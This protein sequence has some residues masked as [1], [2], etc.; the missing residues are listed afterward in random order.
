MSSPALPLELAAVPL[1]AAA[2]A[3]YGRVIEPT[4]TSRSVNLGTAL[5]YDWLARLENR[6]QH[7]RLNVAFFRCAAQPLPL[8]IAL[9]ERHPGSTQLFVPMA[10]SPYLVVV[11]GEAGL[12]AFIARGQGIAYAPGV[13]HA[14]LMALEEAL[15]LTMLIHEDVS[16]GDTY[17][18]DLDEPCIVRAA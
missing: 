15:D 18:R 4:G 12:A 10:P 2:F 14:P 8:T 5:R 13:W 16:A 17:L 1:T 7:A 9:L 6:R 11:D 3:P